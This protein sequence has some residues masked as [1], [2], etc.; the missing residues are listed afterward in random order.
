MDLHDKNHGVLGKALLG[1]KVCQHDQ[2]EMQHVH[3]SSSPQ[4]EYA[5]ESRSI[6]KLQTQ[7]SARQNRA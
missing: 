1:D 7:L 6:L 5:Y 2:N 3:S 4:I